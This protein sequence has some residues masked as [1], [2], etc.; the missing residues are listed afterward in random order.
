MSNPNSATAGRKQMYSRLKL[1]AVFLLF[2]GPLLFAFIWYYGLGAALA[3]KEQANHSP[4][5]KPVV[6]LESFQN[7]VFPGGVIGNE[8]LGRK[9]TIVHLIGSGC[10][11]LCQQSLYNT[12]QTRIAV[13]RDARRIQRVLL[14]ADP[15]IAGKFEAGQPDASFAGYAENG[16]ELQMENLIR[17]L[18]AGKDDAVLIDP[19]GNMMMVIPAD[20]D[21]RLLIKDMK[22][23]L[24]LSRIG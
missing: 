2:A 6:P 7:P 20:L 19:L 12:R 24:K 1:I 8:S 14:F 9:W 11:E 21:P 4:L 3:P 13:G 23:L 18:G 22:K 5:I 17:R 15:G 16:L 10:A